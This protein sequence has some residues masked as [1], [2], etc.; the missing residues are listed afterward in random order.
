M[1]KQPQNVQSTKQIVVGYC[2]EQADVDNNFQVSK[3]QAFVKM[4]NVHNTMYTDQT[5]HL[6]FLSNHGNKLIMLLFEVDGNDI[7]VEP[8]KDS[9]D[10]LLIQA[11]KTLWVQIAATAKV[12]PMMHIMDNKVSATF[13][14]EI[15]KNCNLQ[16]VLLD[17]HQQNL[18]E[19]AIQTF[20]NPFITIL[21]GVDKSFPM[22][23]WDRLLPQAKLTLNLLQ[24]SNV[25]P[26]V[27]AYE[28][29]SFV[30]Q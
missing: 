19:Q 9:T 21:S 28:F 25:D 13:K 14:M 20:N 10:M 18:A 3:W 6:Q 17:K 4:F 12:W 1:K 29:N 15:M 5:G 16:L 27:S 30:E 11:Y 24:K 22:P 8:M 26:R 7:A 23:L 2:D